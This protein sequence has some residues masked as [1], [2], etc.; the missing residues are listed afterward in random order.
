MTAAIGPILPSTVI[1]PLEPVELPPLQ[2]KPLLEH[3]YVDTISSLKTTDRE[4]TTKP[5]LDSELPPSQQTPAEIFARMMDNAQKYI[6]S[7]SETAELKH[8]QVGRKIRAQEKNLRELQKQTLEARK[9]IETWETRHMVANCIL[10]GVTTLTGVGLT[11][12]GN[13]WTGGSLIASGVGSTASELMKHYK[14]NS[15][16]T[17][18]TSIVSGLIGVVGGVGSGIVSLIRSPTT[19]AS[20]LTSG[21]LSTILQATG[22]VTSLVSNGLSGYSMIEKNNTSAMLSDLE[23][24]QTKADSSLRLLQQKY[25]SATMAFQGT[26]KNFSGLF[27]TIAKTHNRYTR[28]CMRMLT[29]DFPA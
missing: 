12:A 9:S 13:P 28:D 18:A 19:F 14:W 4:E 27:K 7:T 29:A 5:N 15:T 24:A 21:T 1:Q 16:L 20:Q 2:K 11:L 17:A 8:D 6:K 10:N 3:R 26:V 23:S 22:V 25:G